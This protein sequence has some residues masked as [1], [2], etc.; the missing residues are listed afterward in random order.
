MFLKLTAIAGHFMGAQ[1]NHLHKISHTLKFVQVNKRNIML[2]VKVMTAVF[3]Y[4]N[5]KYFIK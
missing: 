1:G 3:L 5:L 4:T 2:V